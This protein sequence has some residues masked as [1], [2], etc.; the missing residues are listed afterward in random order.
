MKRSIALR[1]A[2]LAEVLDCAHGSK[3]ANPADVNHRVA[4]KSPTIRNSAYGTT[5]MNLQKAT[6]HLISAWTKETK[7][8]SLRLRLLAISVVALLPVTASF[9]QTVSFSAA[10]NFAAGTGAR[11]VAIGDLNGDGKPDL[12]VA[13]LNSNN[14]SILL[15]TA[16]SSRRTARRAVRF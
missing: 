1:C 4:I 12:A 16:V 11:F 13:N 3:R 15:N 7:L 14:V 5:A 6:T 10:T 2:I 9:A 8:P